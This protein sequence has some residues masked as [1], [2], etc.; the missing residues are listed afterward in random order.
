MLRSIDNLRAM[1]DHRGWVIHVPTHSSDFLMNRFSIYP[2]IETLTNNTILFIKHITY[3]LQRKEAYSA[4]MIKS[5]TTT[6]FLP[7]T[8]TA[9]VI[10]IAILCLVSSLLLNIKIVIS[11]TSKDDSIAPEPFEFS[12]TNFKEDKNL[13]RKDPPSSAQE[14]DPQEIELPQEPSKKDKPEMA[15]KV[16]EI[17]EQKKSQVSCGGHF[18]AECRLCPQGHGQEWYVFF[19][20]V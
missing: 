13:T 17:K 8:T 4:I 6:R 19:G 5:K 14:E 10:V 1:C 15:K 11:V 18:A 7:R 20:D 2:G 12:F 9:A 16:E 3:K